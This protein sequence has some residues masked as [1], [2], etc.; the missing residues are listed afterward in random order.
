MKSSWVYCD[1]SAFLKLYVKEKGSVEARDF[2]RKNRLLSSGILLTEC[3]SALSRKKEMGEIEEDAFKDLAKR[4]KNDAKRL[5]TITLSE[6]VLQ[7]AE[8]IALNT[9]ARALDALHIASALIFREHS[10][11]DLSFLTSDEKQGKVTKALGL[12]TFLVG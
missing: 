8:E 6:E 4:L 12:K 1:T 5:E 11:F 3:Y 7:Q 9:S 2:A 10:R